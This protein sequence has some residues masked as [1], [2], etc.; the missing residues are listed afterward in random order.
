V[1]FN[2][3]GSVLKVSLPTDWSLTSI[4]GLEPGTTREAVAKLL[5]D[6]GFDL[7]ISCI[8]VR[9]QAT[10]SG[11]STSSTIKV[12]APTFTR[13]LKTILKDQ[14][15][16][17]SVAQIPIDTNWTNCR[18]VHV[19]WHKSTRGV[20]MNFSN[21]EIAKR[22]AEKFNDGQYKCLGQSVKSSAVEYSSGRR[23]LTHNPVAWT[24]TLSNVPGNATSEDIDQAIKAPFDKPKHVELGAT[25]YQGSEVE[26]SIE[27][28]SQLEKHGTLEN[29]YLAPTSRGKRAN[30][31]ALFEDESDARSACSL[32]NTSLKI[33]ENGKLTVSLI[34]SAKFKVSTAVYRALISRISEERKTW[35]EKYL[36]F[37]VYADTLNRF[38]TLKIEGENAKEVATARKALDKILNGLVLMDGDNKIWDSSI[39]GNGRTYKR[40]KAI[41]KELNVIIIRDGSK[42]KLHF[43]GPPEKFQQTVDRILDMLKNESSTNYEI[44]LNSQQF[45]WILHGGIKSIEEAVGKNVAVFN[46][47]S[48]SM[49]INGTQAQYDSV[50]AI[51]PREN[52]VEDH[53]TISESLPSRE[54]SCPIC[55]CETDNP[56]ETSCK[57]TYCLEC[58]EDY[59]KSAASSSTQDFQIKCQGDEGSCPAA[60][61]LLELQDHISSSTFET[62]L[63]S[64]FENY[65]QRHQDVFR[66]CPTPDCGYIYRCSISSDP[67]PSA[68]TCPKFFEGTILEN[69]FEDYVQGH[70]RVVRYCLTPGCWYIYRCPISSDRNPPV[71]TCPNCFEA[72]CT[73]CHV[74]HGPY[75]CAEYKDIASGGQEALRKL[76]KELNIK[77][78]PKCTTP[79]EKTEGCNHMTC[80]ACKAHICWVCLA[81]FDGSGPCYK[82]LT[83]AH[84]GIGIDDGEGAYM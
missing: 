47:I 19:S 52:I 41:E 73:Y 3:F 28:R 1:A 79:I 62:V 4:T 69:L 68:H 76:K 84:G 53:T 30:V 55:F 22:V 70:Q 64:S 65:I 82:H 44:N 43:Y 25:S 18:K 50:V 83:E 9:E 23:G 10:A 74:Q 16:P 14:S 15:L 67:N 51:I 37:H 33:L 31:I 29:F 2:R 45:S 34:H 38:M 8:R 26:V 78:C 63:E 35:R 77:D 61:T 49:I 36:A 20:W 59:C 39:S 21:G 6:L 80:W 42:H 58:F 54:T 27:V 66:Y 81:V 24:V 48:R 5:R 7:D 32:N 56:I 71:H 46:V 72:L 40:L 11:T 13:E 60:F 57:H 12:E 17:I 75:S